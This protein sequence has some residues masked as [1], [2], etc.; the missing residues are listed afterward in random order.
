MNKKWVDLTPITNQNIKM[1]F[2]CY[3]ISPPLFSSPDLNEYLFS[4][5]CCLSTSETKTDPSCKPIVPPCEHRV[6]A[7]DHNVAAWQ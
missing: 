2:T 5:L 3:N 4:L 1:N 6:A 7:C